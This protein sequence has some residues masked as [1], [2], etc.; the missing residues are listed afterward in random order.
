MRELGSGC[1]K[2]RYG[3]GGELSSKHGFGSVIGGS[4]VM[5]EGF[6]NGGRNRT[7]IGGGGGGTMREGEGGGIE[8]ENDDDEEEEE[9]E[10]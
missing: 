4:S 3:D 1:L 9:E 10:V 7:S 5:E 2:E 8:N 6:G